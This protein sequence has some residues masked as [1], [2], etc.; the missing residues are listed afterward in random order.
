MKNKLSHVGIDVSKDTLDV[1][2]RGPTGELQSA[3]FENTAA[4]HGKLVKW[5]LKR[6][7]SARVVLEATGNYSLDVALA[8][9]RTPRIE[10]M[11]LNPRAARRFAE[12]CL[13]RSSTDTTMA[14]TLSE[15]AARMEFVAWTPP[16]THILDLRAITRRIAALIV[17]RTREL[18]RAHAASSSSQTPRV[19][20]NDLEVNA[21]HLQRRIE[22]LERHALDLIAKHPDLQRA[23]EHITSVGGFAERSAAQLLGEIM[24]LPQD[25]SAPQWVAHAGIDPRHVDS[26]TSVHKAPRISRRGNAHIR[27]ILYMPA[28]VAIQKEP[29]VRAFY[30]QLVGRGKM[31]MQA[32]VAVMR[33]L[34]ISVHAM[35]K[36]DVD[37]DGAKFRKLPEAA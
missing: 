29:N 19:V 18:N 11:V 8:M 35:L 7:R 30:D 10:V 13:Q 26:G 15:F 31:K 5:L 23:A 6:G 28:L 1:C 24:A 3:R 21:R 22:E 20:I 27:R 37:F 14:R 12:A 32:I 25:M 17:E 33:K 34:L 16:A 4:A 2:S 36:Y 9:H